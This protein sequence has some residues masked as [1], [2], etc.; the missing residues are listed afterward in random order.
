MMIKTAETSPRVLHLATHGYYC[1]KASFSGRTSENPLLYSGLALAGANRFIA[2]DD[3]DEESSTGLEDGIMTSLEASGLN[4]MGTELVVL[5]AC[6]SGV[7]SVRNGEGVFGLRR[8]FQLAGAHTV[9][10]SMFDVPDKA[11]SMLMERF[12]T[13]WLSE[14]TKAAALREASLSMLRERREEKGAAHPLFWGGFILV[15]DPN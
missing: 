15:G 12:Y 4:L 13:N 10:M 6:Q 7:G 1:D 11:T 5:S 9:L 14:S 8:A 2:E 3:E